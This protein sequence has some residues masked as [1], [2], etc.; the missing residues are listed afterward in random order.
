LLSEG[1]LNRLVRVR[2][3]S[4]GGPEEQYQIIVTAEANK[5]FRVYVNAPGVK[6][7]KIGEIKVKRKAFP[8]AL[9]IE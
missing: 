5:Q 8:E 9:F 2:Q 4:F 1:E 7:T 6:G 3:K